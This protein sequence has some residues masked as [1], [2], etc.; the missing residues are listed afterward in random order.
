MANNT[1]QYL[2]I[3]NCISV[4]NCIYYVSPKQH[5][6]SQVRTAERGSSRTERENKASQRHGV[7]STEEGEGHD[8]G[9]EDLQRLFVLLIKSI[10]CTQNV[11]SRSHDTIVV[12]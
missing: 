1:E 11:L 10:Q 5:V 7:L 6:L 2:V 9:G 3:L 12:I 4:F 8:R